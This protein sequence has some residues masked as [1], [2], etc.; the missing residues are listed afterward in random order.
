M[1]RSTGEILRCDRQLGRSVGDSALDLAE[2]SAEFLAQE[3]HPGRDGIDDVPIGSDRGAGVEVELCELLDRAHDVFQALLKTSTR[4]VVRWLRQRCQPTNPRSQ[5]S[6][7]ASSSNSRVGATGLLTL[8]KKFPINRLNGVPTIIA[9]ADTRSPLR[10]NSVRAGR[11][12]G[13]CS[14]TSTSRGLG[15]PPVSWAI[16]PIA[17]TAS[18]R[19]MAARGAQTS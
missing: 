16:A 14:C 12:I 5:A 1:K 19:T 8:R 17:A 4:L 10:V 6:A 11:S 3:V 9:T 15:R 7:D 18:S 13:P 2:R